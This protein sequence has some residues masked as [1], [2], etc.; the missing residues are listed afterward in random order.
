M[1]EKL[2]LNCKTPIANTHHRRIR[3]KKCAQESKIKYQRANQKKHYNLAK[4]R[5]GKELR[6]CL[7][8]KVCIEDRHYHAIRC[9]KCAAKKRKELIA[10]QDKKAKLLKSLKKKVCFTCETDITHRHNVAKFCEECAKKRVIKKEKSYCKS[11]IYKNC[12][13]CNTSITHLRLGSKRCKKCVK[14]E[15]KRKL[16]L[17]NIRHRQDLK[18]LAKER[19]Q[20]RKRREILRSTPEGREKIRLNRE[21]HYFKNSSA[22]RLRQMERRQEAK[23]LPELPTKQYLFDLQ[24]EIC[25]LTGVS[26]KG[27]PFRD[28]HIDHI[29]PMKHGGRSIANNLCLAIGSANNSKGD[30]FLLAW[31][32]SPLYKPMVERCIR[33][34]FYT[35]K[36]IKR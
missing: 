15:S 3:C 4:E 9:K 12:L 34:N 20:S 30:K 29:M 24:C 28:L 17:R 16:R 35:S 26:M 2:C 22:L 27:I 11:K 21:K 19:A 10:I 13:D 18:Y 32:A 7:D 23:N 14:E 1:P 8:C 33:R 5:E 36:K 25:A 6:I 31:M